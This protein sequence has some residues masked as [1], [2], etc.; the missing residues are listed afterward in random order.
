MAQVVGLDVCADTL[1]GDEMIRGISGGQKKRVTTGEMIVGPKQV[2]FADEI[3]TGLDS[4]TTF[5][6]MQCL[7]H[8][9]HFQSATVLV[10]L[11]QPAPETYALFDDVLLLAEGHVVFH[12]P[13]PQIVTFFET[14]GF[15]CP[16]RKGVAD[17]LQEVTSVKDQ[18]QYWRRD[19]PYRYVPVAAFSEAFAASKLG[20]EMS[21]TLDTAF[22]K[23][24]SHPAALVPPSQRFGLQRQQLF[25]ALF[26]REWLLMKRNSAVYIAQTMN[27][28]ILA[29]ITATVFFRTTLNSNSLADGNSYLGAIFFALISMLF[30]GF[31]EMSLLVKRLPVFYKQ[32]DQFLFPSWV[33]AI[34]MWILSIPFS[35]WTSM[36]WC[37]L[38]YYVIGFS[39]GPDRFFKQ[40]LTLFL[41]HQVAI[42]MFRNI[43]GT[44]RTMVVSSTFGAFTLITLFCLGGFVIAKNDIPVYWI[45]GFWISPLAYGEN[46][47]TNNEFTAP[48]WQSVGSTSTGVQ[49][50]GSRVEG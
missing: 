6:I 31:A 33:Y 37:V 39:P 42:A 14:Q 1:V 36:V 40:W 17:F 20:Q 12:G 5:N 24:K 29:L 21:S 16:E 26:E 10:A 27:N 3:S 49:G 35:L 34:P 44:G 25:E 18:E 11:L 19:S 13:L 47:L 38:T 7:R 22:E 9:T 48:R 15:F 50:L 2:L 43:G 4:S 32:R 41:I 28:I 8:F 45:W 46:A 30:N 23:E